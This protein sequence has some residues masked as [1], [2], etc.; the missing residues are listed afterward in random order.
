ME[1]LS[2]LQQRP[3]CTC[4]GMNRYHGYDSSGHYD[5]DKDQVTTGIRDLRLIMANDC[6]LLTDTPSPS[7]SLVV[8]SPHGI[9]RK[10][11]LELMERLSSIIPWNKLRNPPRIYSSSRSSA[12]LSILMPE[13]FDG[14]HD[15]LSINFSTSN[16]GVGDR[17]AV[18]LYLL[19]NNLTP[20][21]SRGK[22]EESLEYHDS[23]ILEMLKD[24]GWDDSTHLKMLLATREPTAESI[25][26][27]V[28]A[29][30]LRLGNFEI[31]ETML[32][33]GM[34]PNG[35]IET[36]PRGML[37]PLQ[38]AAG[39]GEH[40]L[41]L[42][43]MLVSYKVDVDL[44]AGGHP[45][46]YY[47]IGI[48]DAEIIDALLS[49]GA[50]VT[51]VCLLALARHKS[52]R[53][54]N[55]MVQSII[56]SCPDVNFRAGWQDPSAL[57]QAV[58][59]KNTFII[60]L[61]LAREAE[62]NELVT[63]EFERETSL[64]TILGLAVIWGDMQVIQSLLRACGDMNPHFDG[65]PYISPLTLAVNGQKP[66][67]IGALLDA[68]ID[69]RAVDSEGEMTLLERA[70]RTGNPYLCS[71][72]IEWGAKVDREPSEAPHSTS[73][74]LVAVK[75]ESFATVEFLLRAKARVND[76]Y[77]HAPGSVIGAAI[78]LGNEGLIRMLVNAGATVIGNKL[79]KIGNIQTATLLQHMEILPN[80][81]QTSG[82]KFFAAAISERKHGLAEFL[83][84]NGAGVVNERIQGDSGDNGMTPLAA[85]LGANNSSFIQVLLKSG[86][87]VTDSALESAIQ[88]I[89]AHLADIELLRQLLA[90]F[91]GDA[92]N[93]VVVAVATSNFE[94]LE[95]LREAN[96]DPTLATQH[97]EDGWD[98]EDVELPPAESVLEVA[99]VLADVTVLRYLLEWAQW[100]ARNVGRALTMAIATENY[101]AVDDLMNVNCDFTQEITI[102]YPTYEDEFGNSQGGAKETYTS[103]QAAVSQQQVSI[104]E[105]ISP[106]TD[107]NHLGKG[108]RRRTPLQLAVEKGNMEIVNILLSRGA[109]IDSPPAQ[110][111]GVTTL[112]IAAIQ[113]FIGIARRLL[114]LGADLNEAP[115]RYFGRTAL[116]GAAEHGR[117]DMLQMLLEGGTLIV[118]EGEQQYL[119]AV[120]LAESNGHNAAAR[121]LKSFRETVHLS[122][123]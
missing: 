14:Q 94:S 21:E 112:Q 60:E 49:H 52:T 11:N 64:T 16:R 79:E 69:L 47:A 54:G 87:R 115:A 10:V 109:K 35:S 3:G 57:V 59:S 93:A 85:A 19:S 24:S 107:V 111:G 83:L 39:I 9:P 46:L 44:C 58:Q 84:W 89:D 88:L 74:L 96:I 110:H 62:T 119:K 116:Q 18:E 72:L 97:Y 51:P 76:E 108:V 91:H 34:D 43:E 5:R 118:G 42:V 86:A 106:K 92:P 7:S 75:K 100:S 120:E 71:L 38:F 32:D 20:H 121:L 105:K 13:E 66:E 117:I 98:I 41:Q 12:A 99:V 95:L 6:F 73:A 123:S 48:E 78:E 70:A 102:E 23:Q 50:T 45:A 122:P 104:V 22:T 65:L 56:D 27:K 8:A 25:A 113:G 17:L 63:F 114:D 80:M 68:G 61:L 4:H 31:L 15:V 67:I 90:R 1:L 81:L 55:D 26:E 30:A 103:L 29:S 40:G 36:I 28:F 82:Q 33:A 101:S 77:L 2:L 53:L 37:T